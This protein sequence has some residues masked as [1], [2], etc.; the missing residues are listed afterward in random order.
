MLAIR[1]AASPINYK[2]TGSG[3]QPVVTFESEPGLTTPGILVMPKG[4][5]KGVRIYLS[6]AGKADDIVKSAADDG[7]AHLYIDALGTGELAGIELRFPIYAGRSVAFTA[8]GQAVRAAEA[9]PKLSRHIELIGTGPMSSQAVMFAGL[10]D[11]SFDHV[12]GHRIR[13]GA[14][15]QRWREDKKPRECSVEQLDS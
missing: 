2:E 6:D 3:S 7:F 14:K 13:H 4:A 9:M 5:L 11:P 1:P 15:I 12:T 8:G 10:L